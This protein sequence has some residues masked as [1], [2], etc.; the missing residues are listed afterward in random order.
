MKLISSETNPTL[1]NIAALILRVFAGASMLTHGFPKLEKLMSNG[2]IQFMDFLGLGPIITLVLVVFAEVICSVLLILGLI[3]RFASAVL[4]ITMLVA[5]FVAHGADPYAV[6]EMAVIYFVMYLVVF[7]I[8]PGKFSIDE[9]FT[10][11]EI[12][13]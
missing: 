8:G 11:K 7:L 3:T 9:L 6:K 2:E 4:M 10:K 5:I 1:V 12:R 13:Y